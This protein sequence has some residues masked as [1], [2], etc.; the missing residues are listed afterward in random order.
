MSD[1]LKQLL[2]HLLESAIIRLR[3]VCLC[4][5]KVPKLKHRFLPQSVTNQLGD[6]L[7]GKVTLHDEAVIACMWASFCPCK[8]VPL[9]TGYA[10]EVHDCMLNTHLRKVVVFSTLIVC[11]NV[12][13]ILLLKLG[14]AFK[15]FM[16]VN[17]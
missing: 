1:I 12:P 9:L 4:I 2:L 10:C 13:I 17:V 6:W 15:Y 8:T 3:M 5:H 14:L 11:S 16:Y 7:Q